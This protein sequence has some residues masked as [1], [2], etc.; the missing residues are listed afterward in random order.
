MLNRFI[1]IINI[2]FIHL[3]LAEGQKHRVVLWLNVVSSVNVSQNMSLSVRNE[4]ESDDQQGAENL[5]DCDVDCI[6]QFFV[7]V[8]IRL[9]TFVLEED[10][11]L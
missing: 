11:G 4:D 9:L 8:L 3:R 6:A 7:K 10:S 1:V 2:K 5:Q